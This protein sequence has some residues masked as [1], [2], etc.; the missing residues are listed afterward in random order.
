MIL[1]ADMMLR[2][3]PFRF[4]RFSLMLLRTCWQLRASLT[5]LLPDNDA[6]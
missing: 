5:S 3:M 6:L 1:M 2:A 4:L